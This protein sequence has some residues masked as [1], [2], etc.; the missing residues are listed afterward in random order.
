MALDPESGALRLSSLWELPTQLEVMVMGGGATQGFAARCGWGGGGVGAPGGISN[1]KTSDMASGGVG[2]GAIS[3]VGAS[4][5][6]SPRALSRAAS[7]RAASPLPGAKG[8]KAGSATPE[9][10]PRAPPVL[11]PKE[12]KLLED[13]A[14]VGRLLLAEVH[15]ALAHAAL[16]APAHMLAAGGDVSR[17]ANAHPLSPEEAAAA[18]AAE[19]QA[20]AAAPASPTLTWS[21]ILTSTSNSGRGSG[22]AGSG[23]YALDITRSSSGTSHTATPYPSHM[24]G[25][26][27]WLTRQYPTGSGLL[28]HMGA[29]ARARMAP[30]LPGALLAPHLTGLAS[31]LAHLVQPQGFSA[32]G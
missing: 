6:S 11:S 22:G 20:A 7:S 10:L 30:L 17:A 18:A 13:G 25:G 29:V 12:E 27:P 14:A 9:W 26:G 3:S 31:R 16:L 2:S 15:A 28:D 32:G 8:A 24:H 4:S 1:S 21:P 5:P 19:E 23:P